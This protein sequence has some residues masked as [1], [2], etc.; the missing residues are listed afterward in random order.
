MSSSLASIYIA[1]ESREECS[2]LLWLHLLRLA[3]ISTSPLSLH[4]MLILNLAFKFKL[5]LQLIRVEISSSASSLIPL[6]VME[7]PSFYQ[8]SNSTCGTFRALR[9]SSS[10]SLNGL[11]SDV[12]DLGL[13]LVLFPGRMFRCLE[14]QKMYSPLV[15]WIVVITQVVG[16]FLCKLSCFI[17]LCHSS[18]GTSSCTEIKDVKCY[19]V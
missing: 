15:A 13:G 16:M 4:L 18:Q 17:T 2:S 12:E 3:K 7:V 10:L 19:A 14:I 11:E 6:M 8:H 5:A 1:S 9:D